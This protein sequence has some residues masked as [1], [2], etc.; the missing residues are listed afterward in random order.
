MKD[1]L[2]SIGFPLNPVPRLSLSH[3]QVAWALS[4]GVPPQQQLLDQ[5]RYLRQLGI[6]FRPGELGTGRGYR[7][8]YG[9]DHLIELGVALFGL[10]RGITPR[11]IAMLLVRHRAALRR[12]YRAAFAAQPPPAIDEPWVKSRGVTTP[13][14]ADEV[15]LRLNDQHSDAPGTFEIVRITDLSQILAMALAGEH[16]G[17]A[18]R[19]L[20][21]L[22][23]LVLELVAWAR[24]APETR[25][26]RK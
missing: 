6:P 3:G 20:V 22:T 12:I 13:I 7:V 9:Y 10:R 4:R 23:R 16:P 8:R 1:T 21:P 14:L 15:F 25:P 5:L 24:E 18:T 2:H 11:D 26:G 19:T 17:E